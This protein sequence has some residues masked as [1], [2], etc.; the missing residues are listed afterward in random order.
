MW[1]VTGLD[2][3]SRKPIPLSYIEVFKWDPFT[4]TFS[5]STPEEVLEKS[6]RLKQ[7]AE[8]NGLTRKELLE[9]LLLLP[10]LLAQASS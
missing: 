8:A 5:P 4:D 3:G 1:E 7:I 9:P 6:H 2:L 10:R